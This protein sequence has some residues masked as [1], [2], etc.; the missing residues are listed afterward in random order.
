MRA[1]AHLGLE[2]DFEADCTRCFRAPELRRQYGCDR[3]AGWPCFCDENPACKLCN[4]TGWRRGQPVFYI[5]CGKCGGLDPTCPKCEEGNVP[6]YRCPRK[7]V[8]NE[9]G[10]VEAYNACSRYPVLPNAGGLSE[11]TTGYHQALRVFES[12]RNQIQRE[13]AEKAKKKASREAKRRG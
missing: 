10:V 11:Q 8:E 2:A 1:L 5:L 6:M 3:E 13:A 7:L 9:P 12:E 4:G